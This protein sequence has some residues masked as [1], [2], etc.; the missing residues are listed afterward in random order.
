MLGKDIADGKL[1]PKVKAKTPAAD[2]PRGRTPNV[3]S[4]VAGGGRG[5]TEKQKIAARLEGKSI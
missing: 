2:V 3:R 1:K 4:N 5:M